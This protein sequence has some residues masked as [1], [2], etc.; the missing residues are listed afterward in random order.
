MTEAIEAQVERFAPGFRDTIIGR[1]TISPTQY[2]VY[3]PN[4]IGGD[5]G[6]GKFGLPKI[7]QL[8][9]A[10]PFTLGSG[11]FIGSSAVPPGGGVHGMCGYLASEAALRS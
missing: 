2:Q 7:F 10:R 3:N 4:Y 8:G 6:G 9:A 1:S 11:V 5:I